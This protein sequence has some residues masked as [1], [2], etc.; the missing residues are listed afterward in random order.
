[1][2]SEALRLASRPGF[3]NERPLAERVFAATAIAEGRPQEAAALLEKAVAR[4]KAPLRYRPAVS[5]L[6][7][8]LG[9]ARLAMGDVTAAEQNVEE[10]LRALPIEMRGGR[11]KGLDTELLLARIDTARGRSRQALAE[12]QRMARESWQLGLV[13][14]ALDAELGIVE[15]QKSPAK[16]RAYARKARSRGFALFARRAL[17]SVAP[18]KTFAVHRLAGT[19]R[20]R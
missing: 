18:R 3:V 1:L 5:A 17:E 7:I 9:R 10:A 20:P 12:F 11:R 4:L 2:G 15:L 8:T 19:I 14:A 6:H 13:T 16:A